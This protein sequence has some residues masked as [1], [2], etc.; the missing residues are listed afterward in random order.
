MLRRNRIQSMPIN[1]RAIIYS[2]SVVGRSSASLGV[3]LRQVDG[4]NALKEQLSSIVLSG[5]SSSRS[6]QIWRSWRR[7]LRRSDHG[8]LKPNRTR[9]YPQIRGL[10][11]NTAY[12]ASVRRCGCGAVIFF[13]FF[14]LDA[15]RRPTGVQRCHT[16]VRGQRWHRRSTP[17]FFLAYN[18]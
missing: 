18:F 6:A 9:I 10:R 1:L 11:L 3:S 16:A 14:S 2:R 4:V 12:G 17:L 15:V 13:E 7:D 8:R 5:S